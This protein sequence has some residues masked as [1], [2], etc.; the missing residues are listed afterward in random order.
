[1]RVYMGL[2]V[3]CKSTVYVAQDEEGNVIGEGEVTTSVEGFEKMVKE[4]GVPAGTRIGLETG[5][6]S[7]WVAR[8]LW[9]LEMEPVV[10]HAAEVRKK[11]RRTRQKSDRRDAFEICDGLRRDLYTSIVYVPDKKVERLRRI[12]SRRRHFVGKQTAQVNAAKFLVRSVGL[13]DEVAS[14]STE[15]A[16]KEMLANGALGE[17]VRYLAMHFEVWKV[18][19]KNVAELDVELEEAVKPFQE[20]VDRLQTVLGVGP[21]VSAAFVAAIGK[22]ER[23]AES[24]QVV[25]YLGLAPSGDDSGERE[26]HG[27]I[28]KQGSSYA[29]AMLCEAAQHAGRANHPLNP[30][31]ARAYAKRGYQKATVTVAQRLARIL[32]RMWMNKEA[33]D[34]S[35][36]R[37]VAERHVRKRTCYYRFPRAGETVGVSGPG[38]PEKKDAALVP[39]APTRPG[40]LAIS[41]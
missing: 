11:A 19:E 2:D 8:V 28:T 20:T 38:N 13:R 24:R 40:I 32:W 5:T 37:V 35:K 36:L 33:F 25:S 12:L 1:M 10:I 21:V 16:W 26:R 17:V 3:H 39:A 14:L 18:T 31:F 41:P 27:K 7:T 23:F 6:Q 34:V 15:A 30:Y 29:R 4:A 9:G 22:P